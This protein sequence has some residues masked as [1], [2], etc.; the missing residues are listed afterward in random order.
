METFCKIR[1][2]YRA[3]ISFENELEKKY[4]ISL[5][6]GMLLCC[7]KQNEGMAS[8]IIAESL[9]L[10]CSNASKLIGSVEKKGWIKR[11]LGEDDKRKM[12]FTITSTGIKKLEEVKSSDIKMEQALEKAINQ[13]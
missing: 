11:H 7:L 6:E 5:N 9:C 12:F 1:D 4:N 3:I 10:T 2:I 13:S 8:T